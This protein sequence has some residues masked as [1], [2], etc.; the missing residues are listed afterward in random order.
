[1]V[2][3]FHNPNCATSRNTLALIRNSGCEPEIILYLE[4]PPSKDQL[5]KLINDMSVPVRDVLREKGTPYAELDLANPKWL[6]EDLLDF[7]VA[8][9]ILIN[10][11]IVLTSLGTKLCRPSE[12]VLDIL[13]NPQ[14]AAFRKEDGELL[15]NEKGLRV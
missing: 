2:T 4:V 6:D 3:I 7:M 12:V 5:K 10:R 1:M 15:I 11:P 14:L 13:A 8:H 9:P